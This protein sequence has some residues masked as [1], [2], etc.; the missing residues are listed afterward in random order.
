MLFEGGDTSN[1]S[2]KEVFQRWLREMHKKDRQGSLKAKI[3]FLLKKLH[4]WGVTVHQD[5]LS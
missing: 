3:N 2:E 1:G 4:A 5:L